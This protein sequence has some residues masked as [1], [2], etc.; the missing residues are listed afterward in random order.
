MKVIY[1]LSL[2]LAVALVSTVAGARERS[3]SSSP[4]DSSC[5]VDVPTG[6]PVE[7]ATGRVT[8]PDGS[9]YTVPP[10]AVSWAPGR[11]S[12]FVGSGANEFGRVYGKTDDWAMGATARAIPHGGEAVFDN[13]EQDLYVPDEPAIDYR[14]GSAATQ[15]VSCGLENVLPDGEWL[16]ILQAEIVWE[17]THQP[18]S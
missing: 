16:T 18:G 12:A 10:C 1:W 11:R 17:G 8:L 9:S 7:P 2:S 4:V 15:S 14:P 13:I 6:A 5:A 3:T